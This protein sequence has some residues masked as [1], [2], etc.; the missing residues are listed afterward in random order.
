[1]TLGV[2]QEVDAL[3]KR[4]SQ[5]DVCCKI[6]LKNKVHELAFLDTIS[7][8]FPPTK[9]KIKGTPKFVKFRGGYTNP[10]P[11]TGPGG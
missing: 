6:S 5:L 1:M 9:I 3:C 10:T 11:Q 7:I 2:T 4:L 8:C